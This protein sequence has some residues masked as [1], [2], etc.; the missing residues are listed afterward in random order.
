VDVGDRRLEDELVHLLMCFSR[1]PI[2][3][4]TSG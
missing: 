3:G 2:G 4:D 1:T